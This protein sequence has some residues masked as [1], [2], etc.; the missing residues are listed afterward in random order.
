[1]KKHKLTAIPVRWL[2]DNGWR[3]K[4]N[5]THP[6][7][8]PGGELNTSGSAAAPAAL[9]GAL[10]GEEHSRC[11]F[12]VQRSTFNVQARKAPWG[13]APLRGLPQQKAKTGSPDSES[14]RPSFVP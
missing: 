6:R 3:V 14:G 1:M 2:E 13:H 12:N 5:L 11:T 7:P 10:A 4:T 8:L 9:A